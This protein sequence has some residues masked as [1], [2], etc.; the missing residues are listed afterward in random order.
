[1]GVLVRVDVGSLAA[2]WSIEDVGE[3]LRNISAPVVRPTTRPTMR[4]VPPVSI[5]GN[6]GGQVVSVAPATTVPNSSMGTRSLMGD[7]VL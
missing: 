1:M 5:D 6:V 4:K 2:A 3:R 7:L